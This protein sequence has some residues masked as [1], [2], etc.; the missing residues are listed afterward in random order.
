MTYTTDALVIFCHVALWALSAFL[1]HRSW[2][3]R[4]KVGSW[5]TAIVLG[6]FWPLAF[7]S[8]VKGW[9]RRRRLLS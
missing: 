4:G 5:G 6:Q 9:L 1:V 3:R 7:Y 8:L 2:R